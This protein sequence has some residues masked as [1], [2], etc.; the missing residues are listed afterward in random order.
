MYFNLSTIK[1]I[2]IAAILGSALANPVGDLDTR[3]SV[4]EL[5]SRI[6]GNEASAL[7]CITPG[8]K[9]CGLFVTYT[10][11][12]SRQSVRT[13]SGGTVACA[14]QMLRKHTNGAGFWANINAIGNAGLNI[15]YNPTNQKMNLGKATWS[16]N[17]QAYLRGRC[18]NEFGWS[19]VLDTS[20]ST[21][22]FYGD[23]P[24]K[25]F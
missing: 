22:S 2:G 17:D 19:D 12:P 7:L 11:G 25:L 23:L 13:Q 20:Q 18:Q 4:S 8:N 15:G 9:K 14:V 16:R 10:N 24:K 21:E 1:A 5:E 3:A 6:A